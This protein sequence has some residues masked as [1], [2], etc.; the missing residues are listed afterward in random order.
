MYVYNIFKIGVTVDLLYYFINDNNYF[1]FTYTL[2]WDYLYK[3]FIIF[4]L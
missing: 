4:K 1:L 2:G 3:Y